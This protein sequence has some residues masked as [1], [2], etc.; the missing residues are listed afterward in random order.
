MELT[1]LSE[2]RRLSEKYGFDFSKTL[3]QNFLINAAVPVKIA[4]GADISGKNVLEIGPG[5]GCL[6]KQLCLRAKKVIAVEIDQRLIPILG[7]TL[8][9]FDN[10][11]VIQNDILKVDLNTLFDGE[12]FSVCANLPY[13]IT[14]PIV[15][16]LLE[17]GANIESVTVMVQKELAHRFVSVPASP[18]YGSVTASINYYAKASTLFS[19]SAGS[20]CPA[21]KVDSAV[22]KLD[23]RP[24]NER[25]PVKNK[26]IF[27]RVIRAAFAMRRKTLVNNLSQEFGITKS[28]A[29]SLLV[30]LGFSPT[31]RGETLSPEQ[32]ALIAD[33]LKQ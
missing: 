1:N 18:E 9:E 31:V 7:E 20:F 11:T 3:G 13:Y 25:I 22:I 26:E 8:A 23:V 16:A 17:S 30:S 28:D 19:V 14:T 24:E 10:V 27:F 6:T 12:K 4:E 2:I 5:I 15:M 29:S 21:P 32:F 33:N